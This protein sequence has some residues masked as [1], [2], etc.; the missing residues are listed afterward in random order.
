MLFRHRGNLQMKIKV[1]LALNIIVSC[2]ALFGMNQEEGLKQ[3]ALGTAALALWAPMKDVEVRQHVNNADISHVY[4]IEFRN[5]KG[6]SALLHNGDTIAVDFFVN[7]PLAG[8]Y[9]G[10]HFKTDNS[11]YSAEIPLNHSHVIFA[12]LKNLYDAQQ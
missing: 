7:G 4:Y 11:G 6:F 10:N 12:E 3:L 2:Q 9:C 1:F 5:G 8:Q